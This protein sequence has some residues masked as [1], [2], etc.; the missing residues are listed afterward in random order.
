MQPSRPILVTLVFVLIA[1]SGC[2]LIADFDRG[3]IPTPSDASTEAEDAGPA[4][5]R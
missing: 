2:E 4:A 3:K 1:L 5:A